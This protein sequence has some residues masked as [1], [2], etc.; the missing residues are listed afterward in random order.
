MMNAEGYM[1]ERVD[2]QLLW[3]SKKSK[4]C[5]DTYK[6]LKLIE[7]ICAALVPFMA[8]MGTRIPLSEWGIAVLGVVIALCVGVSSLFRFHENWLTYRSTLEAMKQEKF[9]FLTSSGIYATEDAFTL[10]VARF[11]SLI[12]AENQYWAASQKKTPSKPN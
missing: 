6:T 4:S 9:L 12:A 1:K 5:Q 2:A 8:G 7:L 11:E 10:F 3:Y